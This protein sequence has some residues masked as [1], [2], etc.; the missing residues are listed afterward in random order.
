MLYETYRPTSWES[1]V[2]QE[3]AVTALTRIAGIRWGGRAIWI[4]GQSGQG[5]T[6]LARL[7]AAEGAEPLNTVELDAGELTPARVRDMAIDSLYHGL[8]NKTGRAYIVNE[9]H[10]LRKD[11]IRSL[12]VE[13]ERIPGH[14]V[15]IFTTTR[16]GQDSLFEDYDDAGPL[17]SRCLAIRLTPRGLAEAFAQVAHDIADKEGLNGKP[18]ESYIRLAKDCRNNMREMLTRIEAGEMLG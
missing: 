1:V 17:L 7:Y 8:G 3:K 18:I 13:L 6:T 5:K 12:L 11:T 14:A 2:G 4:S 16:D 15:W 9:A 10:G